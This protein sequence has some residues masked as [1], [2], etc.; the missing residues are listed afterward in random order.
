MDEREQD[1]QDEI[2]RVLQGTDPIRIQFDRTLNF[3]EGGVV[4]TAQVYVQTDGRWKKVSPLL[5]PKKGGT[6][7][8]LLEVLAMAARVPETTTTT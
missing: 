8:D 6:R 1:M 7:A 4:T 3:T 2:Q 5:L